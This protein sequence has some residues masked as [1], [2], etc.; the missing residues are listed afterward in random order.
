MIAGAF[1]PVTDHDKTFYHLDA[2]MSQYNELS[3]N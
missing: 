2:A 1:S 3:G